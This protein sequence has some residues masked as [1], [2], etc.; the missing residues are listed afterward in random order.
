[1]ATTYEQQESE[2]DGDPWKTSTLQNG[3][4]PSTDQPGNILDK[5]ESVTSHHS[6]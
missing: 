5:C 4:T 3:S 2:E 6:V 1:M